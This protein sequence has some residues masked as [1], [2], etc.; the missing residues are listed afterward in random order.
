[1][2]AALAQLDEK[3][4]TL[5]GRASGTRK[6]NVAIDKW[7]QAQKEVERLSVAPRAWVDADKAH[8]A[9]IAEL[10]RLTAK[11]E[12]LRSQERGLQR[13]RRVAPCW[14]NLMPP[15]RPPVS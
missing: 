7:R 14:C 5:V 12:E 10:T 3:A 2:R 13:M 1:M 8:T 9:T 4:K 11:V 6:L 15:A